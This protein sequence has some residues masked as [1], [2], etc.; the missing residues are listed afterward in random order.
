MRKIVLA[1]L[2]LAVAAPSIAAAQSPGRLDRR[3]DRYD[4]RED[5]RDLR[6][7]RRDARFDGGARDR[8]ED[9]RD[10]REDRADRREDRWD[11]RHIGVRRGPVRQ[12]APVYRYAPP[13]LYRYAPPPVYGYAAPSPIYRYPAPRTTYVHPPAYGYAP[14]WTRGQYLPPQYRGVVVHDFHRY[15]YA[16]PPY[17]TAYYRTDTGQT[18]LAAIATGLIFNVLAN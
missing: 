18:V 5:R 1:T 9:R 14:G 4:R 17:G 10:R 3:E 12:V 13:P 11:D 7:D 8:R 6:E 16:A 15:G 2:A